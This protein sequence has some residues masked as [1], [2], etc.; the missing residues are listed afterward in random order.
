MQTDRTPTSSWASQSLTHMWI[1]RAQE[2]GKEDL[3][4]QVLGKKVNM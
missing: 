3:E 1:N 2:Q 4:Q